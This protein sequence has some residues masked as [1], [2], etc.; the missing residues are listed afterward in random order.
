MI[1]RWFY[2]AASFLLVL[3]VAVPVVSRAVAV[4]LVRELRDL[5]EAYRE[6]EP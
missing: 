6:L 1:F 3:E 2:E 5:S 4:V